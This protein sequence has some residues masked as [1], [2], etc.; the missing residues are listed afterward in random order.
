MWRWLLSW[1]KGRADEGP[2]VRREWRAVS[3]SSQISLGSLTDEEML[4]VAT[5]LGTISFIDRDFCI[6][7]F[8][9]NFPEQGMENRK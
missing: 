4:R 3:P 9:T 6:V 7:F 5:K 1:F 8:N 2:P